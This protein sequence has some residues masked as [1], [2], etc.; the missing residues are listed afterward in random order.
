M[1]LCLAYHHINNSSIDPKMI[2]H[3]RLYL[4]VIILLPLNEIGEFVM[5]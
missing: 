2:Y 3:Y 1:I 4:G 5:Q